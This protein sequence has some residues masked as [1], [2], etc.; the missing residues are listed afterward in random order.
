MG[1]HNLDQ[2]S[3]LESLS[4]T[5][6]RIGSV[7]DAKHI[8]DVIYAL[9]ER[10][11]AK[12]AIEMVPA[13]MRRAGWQH[14]AGFINDQRTTLRRAIRIIE[15]VGGKNDM[16]LV[17]PLTQLGQSYFY[18]DLSGTPSYGS[19]SL[20]TGEAH[21]KRAL[22]IARE[23]PEANWE[24][25]AATSLSLGDYYMF[26][27]NMQQANK[28]YRATWTDLSSSD[29][30]LAY[31]REHLERYAILR[32]NLIPEFVSPPSKKAP[33]GQE[34]PFLQGSVTMKYDVSKRGVATNLKIV[35]AHPREF[36][37]MQHQVQRELRRRIY[38]PQF[39]DAVAVSTNDQ[40][41]VHRFYYRQADLD[42]LQAAAEPE[43]T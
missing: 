26:L 41:L 43:E 39:D 24:M 7:D 22:R 5:N 20:S 18:V 31:R 25:I 32:S 27:G 8:Q 14:R 36:V 11:Y 2:I 6:L 19:S 28:I 42:A 4:E 15:T 34:I 10:A 23:N 17:G 29:A 16:R 21:F 35:E 3:I 13:L 33:T 38:R 1:P 9:N 30:R 37:E 40:I 12:N